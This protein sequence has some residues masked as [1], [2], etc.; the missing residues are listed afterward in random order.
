MF[1]SPGSVL[2]MAIWRNRD[3][4][5]LTTLKAR[6]IAAE[7]FQPLQAP[8]AHQPRQSALRNAVALLQHVAHHRRIEQAE[9]AFENRAEFVAGLQDVDRMDFHQRLQPFGQRRLAAADGAE[10][11]ENLFALFQALGGMS[12]EGDDPLDRLFHA[13]KAFEGGIGSDRPVEEDPAEAGIPRRVYELR[14]TH[15]GKQSLR[16]IGIHQRIAL[17]GLQVFRE[18]HLHFAPRFKGTGEGVEQYISVY[19]W[20]LIEVAIANTPYQ[21]ETIRCIRWC[22]HDAWNRTLIKCYA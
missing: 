7:F 13:V 1:S 4:C 3:G 16:R 18:R 12:K 15:R 2:A 19:T 22:S 14:L 10:Q 21:P 11:I 9:G 5:I 17:A 20:R 6:D 8:G